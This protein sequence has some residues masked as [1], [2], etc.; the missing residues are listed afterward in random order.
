MSNELA[1]NVNPQTLASKLE[2]MVRTDDEIF[3]NL[4]DTL[5]NALCGMN[6]RDISKAAK[7]TATEGGQLNEE[8]YCETVI[9][10][11]NEKL[12]EAKEPL[13]KRIWKVERKPSCYCGRYLYHTLRISAGFIDQ[14]GR[15][16]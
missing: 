9:E 7:D 3:S 12:L 1:K 10:I 11:F 2:E 4:F 15:R 13:D 6:F 16:H 14:D 5:F 8:T